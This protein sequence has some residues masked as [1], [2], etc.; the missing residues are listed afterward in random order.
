MG[1]TTDEQVVTALFTCESD[2]VVAIGE[3]CAWALYQQGRQGRQ[4]RQRQGA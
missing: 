2:V 3:E 4:I 1:A